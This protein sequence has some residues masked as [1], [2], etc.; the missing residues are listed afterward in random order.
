MFNYSL[1]RPTDMD[2]KSLVLLHIGLD[3]VSQDA[4]WSS[5]TASQKQVK[6]T[7]PFHCNECNCEYK[8][9]VVYKCISLETGLLC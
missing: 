9:V 8:L 1:I 5:L 2:V 7:T 4:P 3:L 6:C